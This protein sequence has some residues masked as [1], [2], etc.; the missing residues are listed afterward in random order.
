MEGYQCGIDILQRAQ[1]K[2]LVYGTGE[3]R[4]QKLRVQVQEVGQ[5][6]CTPRR[7]GISGRGAYTH[8]GGIIY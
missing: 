3:D 2:L 6:E 5:A 4:R 1:F 8:R 7:H